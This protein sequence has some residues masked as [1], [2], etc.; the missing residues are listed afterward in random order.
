MRSLQRNQPKPKSRKLTKYELDQFIRAV[1]NTGLEEFTDF[2]RKPW[3]MIWPNF[4]AGIFRGLG[5]LIGATIVITLISWSLTKIIDLPLIGKELEPYIEK[6][7]TEFNK[8]KEAT[9][10]KSDVYRI[11][12][13][14][15]E[16]KEILKNKN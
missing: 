6:V 4:V 2:I 13:E 15:K 14:L 5:L 12:S 3:K 9:N 1:E 7:Q 8:Y 10:Y 11:E 16:I